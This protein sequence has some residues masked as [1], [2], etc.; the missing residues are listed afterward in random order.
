V[1]NS[2]LGEKWHGSNF[3]QRGRDRS[4]CRPCC[5]DTERRFDGRRSTEWCRMQGALGGC[6]GQRGNRGKSPRMEP[7]GNRCGGSEGEN[8]LRSAWLRPSE[9]SVGEERRESLGGGAPA[10]S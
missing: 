10:R 9:R 1:L 4:L 5:G 6:Q 8:M 3:G 2:A 7:A